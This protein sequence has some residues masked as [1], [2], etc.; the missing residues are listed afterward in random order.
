MTGHAGDYA[1]F[2]RHEKLGAALTVKPG[3]RN[4]LIEG[5]MR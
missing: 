1:A 3:G 4:F 5:T 2:I